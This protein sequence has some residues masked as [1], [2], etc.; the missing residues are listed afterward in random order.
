MA[1]QDI[2]TKFARGS[3]IAAGITGLAAITL[4]FA[5]RDENRGYLKTAALTSP[6]I[7]AAGMAMPS[8]VPAIGRSVR[9]HVRF[10]GEAG[11]FI[12][13]KRGA[14]D[15]ISLRQFI[16]SGEISPTIRGALANVLPGQAMNWLSQFPAAAP[17]SLSERAAS[18]RDLTTRMMEGDAWEQNKWLMS[19]AFERTRLSTLSPAAAAADPNIALAMPGAF[20]REELTSR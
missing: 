1:F 4:P 19:Y 5:M 11:K 18:L 13:S 8:L 14:L 3:P 10:A 7:V 9:E 6:F 15:Y 16:E 17:I 2:F 12:L 20:T